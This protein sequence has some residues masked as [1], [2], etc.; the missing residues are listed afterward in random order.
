MRNGFLASLPALLVGA[1]LVLGQ[2]PQAPAP[3][4][5][6]PEASPAQA[7]AAPAETSTAP[8]FSVLDGLATHFDGTCGRLNGN[9]L[10]AD[11][12]YLLWVLKD[13]HVPVPLASTN[14]IGATGNQ[15]LIGDEDLAYHHRPS[16]G[17]RISLAYW[18]ADPL[19]E[20]DWDKPRTWAIEVNYLILGQRGIAESNDTA[21]TL[22]RP[23]FALNNR[24]E[25]GAVVAA[26]GIANGGVTATADYGLWGTELNFWK[27][28]YFDYPGRTCRLD[29]LAGFRY[30]DLGEDLS[31]TSLSA[32][33]QQAAGV[34][35][36]LAGNQ[37]LSND[38][39]STRNQFYGAQIGGVAKFFLEALE[40]NLGT[41]IALGGAAEQVHIDGFQFRTLP[42]G[43]VVPSQGG[44]L[45]LASNIG[46]FHR[47][48]FSVIP[49][50][51]VIASY[52]ICRHVSFQ[53]GY[54]FL[55]WG[56]VLRPGEQIDRVLDVTQIPNFPATGA[57]PTGIARPSVPL[58]VTD[59]WAQGLVA[60]VQITW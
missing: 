26:P 53:A 19:P 44:L 12:D 30:L 10:V 5:T 42:T 11:V 20:M 18:A 40:L 15:V 50:F 22:I 36:P 34:F 46:R 55:Y 41:K 27:N 24:S 56:R 14:A 59:F 2:P 6:P 25:T 29:L 35:A 51:D 13:A 60:G 3:E 58:K 32:Y 38:L 48:E 43:T 7:P 9:V 57:T 37:L 54:E 21:P 33:N 49:E 1:S 47:D 31:I 16:S 52:A 8:S 17:A 45:A 28:V 4:A 23:F 39:F